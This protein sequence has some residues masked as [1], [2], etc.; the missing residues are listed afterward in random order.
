[1]H[2]LR[3]TNAYGAGLFS[4]AYLQFLQA[5]RLPPYELACADGTYTLEFS[6]LWSEAIYWETLALSII[7]ELYY[8]TLLARRSA[9]EREAIMA[10]GTLRLADKIALLRTRPDITFSDFGTRRRFSRSWQEYVVRVLAQELPGQV[11]GT[12]NTAMAMQY[13]LLPMG[14]MGHELYMVMPGLMAESHDDAIRA[15]HNRV[16]QEWW[17]EYGTG[18]SIALTDTYGTDFFFRDMTTAQAHAWRGLRQDSGD[19][20]AFGEQAIAFYER[21]GIDPRDKLIVFSDGLD[22][23]TIIKLAD[24]FAGRVRVSFGWG[25]NLTNDL[26]LEALS[27]V[28]K[29]VE[30]NGRRTVKLSD[31]LAKAT[32]EAHDIARFKRIFGHTVTACEACTY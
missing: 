13:G 20:I 23:G 4:E 28:I 8:R 29:V 24:H 6:G 17:D 9:F 15:S 31:N 27:L 10:T 25:T 19:P 16:L 22:L 7:N 26:G 30:A 32:G 14:T 11:L 2:Y 21:H 18:L 1:V 3:G 5:L 12:S